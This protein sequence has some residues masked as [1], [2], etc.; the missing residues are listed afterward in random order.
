MKNKGF[1]LVELIVVITILA[2]VITVSVSS[3]LVY[4]IKSKSNS[5]D[6]SVAIINSYLSSITNLD[7]IKSIS[8]NTDYIGRQ[9]LFVWK[10]E[11]FKT[12]V[13][14][15]SVPSEI[16]GIINTLAEKRLPESKTE[17]GFVILIRVNRGSLD[18]SCYTTYDF[19]TT[20]THINGSY[21]V[22]NTGIYCYEVTSSGSLQ[23]KD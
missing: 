3:V 1:T 14:Y 6:S 12:S 10:D 20:N 15:S 16:S 22:P 13:S 8:Y 5:D 18:A 19:D 23:K 9:Y 11:L 21:S 7:S 4:I 2:I 17:D